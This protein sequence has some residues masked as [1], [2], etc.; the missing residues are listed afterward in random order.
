MKYGEAPKVE[1]E[2]VTFFP[3]ADHEDASRGVL[4]AEEHFE[5]MFTVMKLGEG[6]VLV[7]ESLALDARGYVAGSRDSLEE[8]VNAFKKLPVLLE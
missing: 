1:V 8:L 5:E 2:G 4:F 3:Y 7:S 6:Y